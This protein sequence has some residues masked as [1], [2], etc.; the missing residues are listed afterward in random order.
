[1]PVNTKPKTVGELRHSRYKVLPVR[2]ELRKNLV[3]KLRKRGTLFPGIVGFD[4]T[5]IP[6]LEN[7]ILAGQD[8]VLLGER[9][10][11][12]SRIIRSMVSLMDEKIPVVAGC[13]I[14][15]N[16]YKPICRSCRDLVTQGG[17]DVEI[18]WL[19]RDARYSENSP[20]R[21]FPSRT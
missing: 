20:R 12:K 7:A 2:E 1:M 8:I 16:P 14:N 15:D 9:G 4:N 11:A 21:I 5:V 18:N 17:D 10:Q 13:E 19:P 3:T 6:Q